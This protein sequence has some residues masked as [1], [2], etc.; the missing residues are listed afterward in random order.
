MEEPARLERGSLPFGAGIPARS[1]PQQI[2]R[3][4][5]RTAGNAFGAA[6][7]ETGSQNAQLRQFAVELR[8]ERRPGRFPSPIYL[9][10]GGTH[11]PPD[12][13]RGCPRNERSREQRRQSLPA[14]TRPRNRSEPVH[15]PKK[16]PLRLAYELWRRGLRL[17]NR[18]RTTTPRKTEL[19]CRQ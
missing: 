5:R 3:L 13:A 16:L 6:I 2:G 4:S 11:A 17:P 9:P 14:R 12:G 15:S 8:A 1:I 18:G 7:R 10:H 19:F